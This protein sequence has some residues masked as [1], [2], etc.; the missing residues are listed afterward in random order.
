[1]LEIMRRT[2]KL[3]RL[4]RSPGYWKGL[5]SGV[6]AAIEHE[7]AIRPLKL[8]SV[9]DVGANRGQFSILVAGLF[10]NAQI[11]AFEPLWE[12]AAVYKKV[13]QGSSRATLYPYAAGS[14]SGS[15]QIHISARADSSSLLPISQKQSEIFPGT[16]QLATRLIEVRRIDDVLKGELFASPLMVKLDVQGFELAALQGMPEVLRQADYVYAEITFLPLYGGQP[17]AHEVIDWLRGNG[18]NLQGIYNLTS[19]SD[20]AAVQADALFARHVDSG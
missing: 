6:A 9:I 3:L 18:F 16:E 14:E 11:R 13:F 4:L 1:M 15:A 20:G 7:G 10:P 17:L 5:Q 19:S 12:A 2:G 8:A